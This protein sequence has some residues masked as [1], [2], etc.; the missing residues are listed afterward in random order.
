MTTYSSRIAIAWGLGMT[1]Q[2]G[3]ER[4]TANSREGIGNRNWHE[5][6]QRSTLNAQHS[7]LNFEF[8]C[9]VLR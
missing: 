8:E 6:M 1:E 2:V 7:T 5:L 3:C 4:Y 9:R